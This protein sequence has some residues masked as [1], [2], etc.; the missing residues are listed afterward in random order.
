[1]HR[2]QIVHG[3][4]PKFYP[5]IDSPAGLGWLGKVGALELHVPQW[6]IP[7]ATGPSGITSTS[8]ERHPDRVVFDLDPGP[9]V[10]L[11]ECAEVALYL[12]E[13]LDD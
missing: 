11:A 7:A 10:G 12:R 1:M 9:G 3:S 4:G 2:V 13:R 6:R 8:T 5:I